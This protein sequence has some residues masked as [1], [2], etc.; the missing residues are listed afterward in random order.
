MQNFVSCLDVGKLVA[1]RYQIV[2]ILSTDVHI[3]TY[4]AQDT[5]QIGSP[6]CIVKQV[7]RRS[8]DRTSNYAAKLKRT[9]RRRLTKEA[10]ILKQLGHHP[11]MPQL[12]GFFQ[13]NEDLYLVQEFF[14]G[15]PLSQELPF[16]PRYGKRYTDVE[17]AEMLE[18]LLSIL[19][20]VHGQG[21]IHTHLQPQNIIRHQRDGKLILTDFSSAVLLGDSHHQ[22]HLV[23]AVPHLPVSIPIGTFGYVS[24]EQLTGHPEPHSDIYALG[25]IGIQAV[26]GLHPFHLQVDSATATITWQSQI[27]HSSRS[28][29][30][31]STELAAILDKMVR[32]HGK[33]RYQSAIEVMEDLYR[34]YPNLPDPTYP[35]GESSSEPLGRRSHRIPTTTAQ[36]T[37]PRNPVSPINEF[38]RQF[39]GNSLLS[40]VNLENAEETNLNTIESEAEFP[41]DDSLAVDAR[42]PEHN[43][44][45]LSPAAVEHDGGATPVEVQTP[46]KRR[47]S[48]L[49]PL[50]VGMSM[51]IA[52]NAAII[53]GAV[54]SLSQLPP[55][56]GIDL[57]T[58][59]REIYQNGNL[60]QAIVLVQSITW[61]SSAYQQAQ[62]DAQRWQVDWKKAAA[63]FQQIQ[64]AYEKS[65][66]GSVLSSAAKMPA[67]SHW[68]MQIEPMVQKAA[69]EMAPDAEQ[70]LQQ[71]Y[72]RANQKDFASAISLLKKVSYGTPVYDTAQAQIKQYQEQHQQQLEDIA[73]RQL[74]QAYDRAINRDF[75]GA[76]QLLSQIPPGT[77][78]YEIVQQKIAEYSQKQ[79][80]KA[81]SV[82][83]QAYEKAAARDY[84]GAIHLLRQVPRGT[85][86][87]EIGQTKIVQYSQHIQPRRGRKTRRV[88]DATIAPTF[89]PGDSLQEIN[90]SWFG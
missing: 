80:I 41:Q 34:H 77:S 2:Q 17:C 78:A 83:Q 40:V 42:S 46:V 31:V 67:I 76:L 7:S 81:N 13:E 33:N 62:D 25:L 72:D 61:D 48:P 59:A 4:L 36:E 82:L 85:T 22:G 26:T 66:W 20:L 49:Q 28:Q 19:A 30:E 6:K 14:P 63:E 51:G 39:L 3:Q 88:S 15:H 50:I 71:A 38:S 70:F 74:Q 58:K 86:A 11:Q 43:S 18:E 16:S 10:Q 52:V 23:S 8:L 37:E 69:A 64:Q 79:E 57:L 68:Q 21:L 47:P 53:L 5:H 27:S 54:Y 73:H 55:D 12:L 24:P 56:R 90:P 44:E 1:S 87:Y 35:I 65:Q 45:S 29:G 60:D 84:T 32:Y 9:A 75:S 89:N